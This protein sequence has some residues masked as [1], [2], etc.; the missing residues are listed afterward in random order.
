VTCSFLL[1][2]KLKPHNHLY[3]QYRD[4]V[5]E[6][7]S[8]FK[9]HEP[10]IKAMSFVGHGGAGKSKVKFTQADQLRVVKQFRDGNYNTL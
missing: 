1:C 2:A 6:I 4:S 10:L 9:D 5:E 8:L 3:S 7:A